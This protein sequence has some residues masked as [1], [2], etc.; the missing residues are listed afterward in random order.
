MH[1]QPK[2]KFCAQFLCTSETW[3]MRKA[4]GIW[5]MSIVV[6]LVTHAT[7]RLVAW[8]TAQ[9]HGVLGLG[10]LAVGAKSYAFAISPRA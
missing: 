3:L 8:R 10:M 4:L 7:E 5:R 6:P 1:E 9:I 2:S